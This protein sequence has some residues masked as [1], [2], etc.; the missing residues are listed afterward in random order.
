MATAE[1]T[2]KRTGSGKRSGSCKE[3][4]ATKNKQQQRTSSNGAK[5][6]M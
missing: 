3:Q 2:N 6:G 4:A 1:A 5:G